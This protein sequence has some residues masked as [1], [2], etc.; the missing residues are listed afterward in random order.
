M[1]PKMIKRYSHVRAQAMRDA[2]NKA[3]GN[4]SSTQ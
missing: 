4:V 3:F 2:I 1:S